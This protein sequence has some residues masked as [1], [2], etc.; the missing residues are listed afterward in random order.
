M[1]PSKNEESP[2]YDFLTEFLVHLKKAEA[3]AH[4]SKLQIYDFF[5]QARR[6]LPSSYL[7]TASATPSPPLTSVAGPF[8]LF[9]GQIQIKICSLV[10]NW[11]PGLSFEK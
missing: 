11:A 10:K 3:S 1:V 2:F 5:L 8:Q 6:N 7:V 4:G 9:S